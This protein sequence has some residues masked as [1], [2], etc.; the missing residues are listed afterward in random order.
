[1]DLHSVP[2]RKST[3]DPG[4]MGTKLTLA[5]CIEKAGSHRKTDNEVLLILN[6]VKV[7]RLARFSRS[8]VKLTVNAYL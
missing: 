7:T 4:R 8:D 6:V 2:G 3:K 1:M 5:S